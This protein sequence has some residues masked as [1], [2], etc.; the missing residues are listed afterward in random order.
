MEGTI[1]WYKC[2]RDL[3]ITLTVTIFA[4]V[5]W[6]LLIK[7][8]RDIWLFEIEYLIFLVYIEMS[9]ICKE[10]FW[11]W[12]GIASICISYACLLDLNIFSNSWSFLKIDIRAVSF[13]VFI[14][15]VYASILILPIGAL[16]YKWRK[17]NSKTKGPYLLIWPISWLEGIRFKGFSS[18]KIT[19]IDAIQRGMDLSIYLAVI[20]F[21][22]FLIAVHFW[23]KTKG[24]P[25]FVIKYLTIFSWIVVGVIPGYYG[26]GW[27]YSVFA[28]LFPTPVIYGYFEMS[29]RDLKRLN[30][31][32][33]IR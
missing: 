2:K 16:I 3:W 17:S 26:L 1:K 20:S 18:Y 11:I 13:G 5:T 15:L 8:W 24:K 27:K 29:N 28:L 31:N 21:C 9:L 7:G 19:E 25:Q 14:N 10:H 22:I 6:P 30:D 12:S 32:I 23:G 4:C 33:D